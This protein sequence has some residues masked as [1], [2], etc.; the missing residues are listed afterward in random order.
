[1]KDFLKNYWALGVPLAVLVVAILFLV[2][3]SGDRENETIVGMIDATNV[4]VAAEFPGRLDSLYVKQGDTVQSGQLLGVLRTNEIDAIRAQAQAGIAAA[5]GQL[6]LLE[7]GTRPELVQSAS[8]LYQISQ[9]QYD[10]FSK[11]NDRMQRLY[12]ADV[13]SGQEKDIFYFKYQASKKEMETARL[14]LEMLQKGVSP[15]LIQS[16]K[17]IVEQAEQAYALTRALHDNTRIYAPANGVITGLVIHQGEIVAIGYPIMTIEKEHSK[18]LRFNV[19]QDRS[20]KLPLGATAN[21]N[22]P[23]CEPDHFEV[24]VTSV[25]PSLDFANWVPT[26]DR[27]QFELRTFTIECRPGDRAAVKGLRSGMTAALQLPQ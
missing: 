9:D 5:R 27:G 19:R 12:N 15:E 13:I 26:K 4:D 23:G 7:K 24:V 16:A 10:L 25:S 18:V 2:R 17:A 6:D 22:V 20:S 11:T 1:M 21:V 8:K 14:N 3:K